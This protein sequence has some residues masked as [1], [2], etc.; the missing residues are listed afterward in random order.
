MLGSGRPFLVEIQNA[1]HVPSIMDVKGIEEKINKS[2]S[3]LVSEYKYLF[4]P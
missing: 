4:G 2:N 3:K 1:R